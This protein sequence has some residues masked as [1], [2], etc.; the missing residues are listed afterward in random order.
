MGALSGQLPACTTETMLGAGER[1]LK[2]A[3]Q[4][5]TLRFWERKNGRDHESVR[6]RRKERDGSS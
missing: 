4:V 2:I 1:S 5:G 3:V 6:Y